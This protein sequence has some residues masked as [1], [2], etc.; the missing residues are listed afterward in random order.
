MVKKK[1]MSIRIDIRKYE[2]ILSSL[3][4]KEE[5]P[6]YEVQDDILYKRDSYHQLLRC[7]PI[8]RRSVPSMKLSI[9]RTIDENLAAVTNLI[10]HVLPAKSE[11][12]HK[13]ATKMW[14][15]TLWALYFLKQTLIVIHSGPLAN[16]TY[17]VY[18]FIFLMYAIHFIF[19]CFTVGERQFV[20]LVGDM[21]RRRTRFVLECKALMSLK[22]TVRNLLDKIKPSKAFIDKCALW[23]SVAQS[24]MAVV[25]KIISAR[26]LIKLL[27]LV[28]EFNEIHHVSLTMGG[29]AAMIVAMLWIRYKFQRWYR[30][31][32][33]SYMVSSVLPKP[34]RR[35]Q[36]DNMLNWYMT[37]GVE[38]G[39]VPVASPVALG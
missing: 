25:V 37:D 33:N 22:K 32:Q 27:R 10:Y 24:G 12:A 36:V 38:L 16:I 14:N 29:I 19:P 18:M 3:N 1:G 23:G 34:N 39:D 20:K 31:I 8:I 7:I 6:E 21:L 2:K 9:I 17:S 26:G 5:Y 15:L 13:I 35:Q 30:V 4:R 11:H 28:M